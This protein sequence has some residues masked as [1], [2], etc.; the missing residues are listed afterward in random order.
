MKEYN[1]CGTRLYAIPKISEMK[2]FGELSSKV[3][4]SL[5]AYDIYSLGIT[6]IKIKKLL[7]NPFD[8]KALK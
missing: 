8:Y 3:K 5:K 1:V 6:F 4:M 2:N 7:V